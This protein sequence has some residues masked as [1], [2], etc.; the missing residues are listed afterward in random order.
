MRSYYVDELKPE[1]VI[2]I[3]EY[4]KK[5]GIKSP[6]SDIFWI[7][8]PFSLLNKTQK[9]HFNSCG[10]Y[11]FSLE[12]GIDWIKLELLIRPTSTLRCSCIGYSNARQ[13]Q[14]IIKFIDS[15]L[16]RLNISS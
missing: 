1:A 3:K 10:P 6:I 5:N 12:T 4:L 15:I 13:R 16:E 7:E 8:V 14:Y 9:E 11:I 2:R